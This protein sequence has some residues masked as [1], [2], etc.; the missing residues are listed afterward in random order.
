M[1]GF[2]KKK[3]VEDKHAANLFLNLTLLQSWSIEKRG[4]DYSAE[5]LKV[6]ASK[7]AINIR[8]DN[9]DAI[10]SAMAINHPA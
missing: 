3:Q 1:F 5:D 2:F 8:C 6:I 10:A 7:I 9:A 4:I